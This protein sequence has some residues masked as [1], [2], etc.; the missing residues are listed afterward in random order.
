M[1]ATSGAS[2]PTT[3]KSIAVRPAEGDDRGVIGEVE[4]DAFGLA[5]DAGIA[6]RAIEPVRQRAR[7]DLPGE[8]VLASAGADGGECS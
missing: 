1:P 7:R 4:R 3:T 2:G 6:R 5:R 8:R